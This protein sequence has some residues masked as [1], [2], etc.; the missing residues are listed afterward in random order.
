MA[1]MLASAMTRLQAMQQANA[2]TPIIYRRGRSSLSFSA[3]KGQT[4]YQEDLGDIG[5]T[6]HTSGDYIFPVSLLQTLEVSSGTVEPKPGDI[7][8]E[9]GRRFEV[10]P[11][12]GDKVFRYSDPGRTQIRVHT[13]QVSS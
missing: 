11:L 12:N 3:T 1:N 8:E 13:K 10:L 9:S 2:A 7:I 5:V 4:T 6:M